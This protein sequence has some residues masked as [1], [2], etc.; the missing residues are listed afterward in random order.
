MRD[1]A[2]HRVALVTL[3]LSPQPSRLA[4]QRRQREATLGLAVVFAVR[5]SLED[6]H[7]Q[8]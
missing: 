4:A 6:L 1:P 8:L 5:H 3:K 2:W 7:A